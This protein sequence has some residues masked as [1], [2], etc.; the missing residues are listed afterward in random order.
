MLEVQA[1]AHAAQ[2]DLEVAAD[3]L[4][5]HLF[6]AVA[7]AI[8]DLAKTASPNAPFQRVAVQGTLSGTV[9][10]LHRRTQPLKI[11]DRPTGPRSVTSDPPTWCVAP[12]T[13]HDPR[14][15]N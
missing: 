15:T 13:G 8:I 4:Q 14:V 1:L 11:V 3:Q 2:L 6:A 12:D 10:E 7:H 5:R 9:G